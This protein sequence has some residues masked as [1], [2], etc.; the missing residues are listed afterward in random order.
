MRLFVALDLPPAVREGLDGWGA[1]ELTDPALRP[2]PAE[3]LHVTLCF[4]GTTPEDRVAD[5]LEAVAGV[6]PRPVPM[7]FVRGPVAKPP[8][9]PSL[10]ALEM[11][12]PGAGHMA[13]EV[14]GAMAARGLARPEERP[15]WPHVTVAR[16]RAEKRA[17]VSG[18]RRPQRVERAPG[19][20]PEELGGEFGAVRLC[21]YR[22][23][24]RRDGSQ[25][26]PLLKRGLEVTERHG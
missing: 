23:M 1:R 25:Y 7:S 10:F 15:F 2:V 17:G 20:L 22:S 11:V 13:R 9:R 14:C 8:R 24:M 26:V 18:R 3:N 21:L 4:L 16:V 12:A 5:A 6:E 19:P